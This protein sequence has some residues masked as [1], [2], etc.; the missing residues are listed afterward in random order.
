MLLVFE[1]KRSNV[2]VFNIKRRVKVKV[3][4]IKRKAVKVFDTK[5]KL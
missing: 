3:F 5:R 1:I 2:K 4:D